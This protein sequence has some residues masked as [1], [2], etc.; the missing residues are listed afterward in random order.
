MM[1]FSSVFDVFSKRPRPPVKAGRPLT[2]EFRYRVLELCT[3]T[4]PESGFDYMF[5]GSTDAKFC[6]EMHEKLS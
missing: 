5:G 1:D 2:A 6:L 4:F 3:T